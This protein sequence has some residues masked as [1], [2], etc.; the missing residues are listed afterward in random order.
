M[1]MGRQRVKELTCLCA[2]VKLYQ[3]IE[4]FSRKR[5]HN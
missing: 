1:T 3:I 5:L 2:F 4:L